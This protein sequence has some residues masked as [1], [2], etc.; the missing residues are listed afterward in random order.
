MKELRHG[1]EA[2]FSPVQYK[3]IDAIALSAAGTW[4]IIMV[5]FSLSIGGIPIVTAVERAIIGSTIIYVATSVGLYVVSRAAIRTD[6]RLRRQKAAMRRAGSGV[7]VM[8]K[9]AKEQ[10]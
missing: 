3:S 10:P 7:E 6:L 1:P 5:M 8:P 4:F 2:S 9:E